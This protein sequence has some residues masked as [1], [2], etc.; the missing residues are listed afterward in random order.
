MD[1]TNFSRRA[2]DLIL[3]SE[4]L[5]HAGWPGGQSGVTLGRGYDLGY[6]TRSEFLT[7]WSPYLEPPVLTL[8]AGCVGI[9]GIPAR[10]RARM[11]R[12]RVVITQAVADRVFFSATL[13]KYIDLTKRTFPGVEKLPLDAQGALVSLVFNRGSRMVDSDP[14]IQ[15][16]RE[17]RAIR[18]A[19]VHGDLIDIAMQIRSMTRLWVGKGLDGLIK[20]REEEAELVEAAALEQIAANQPLEK[21]AS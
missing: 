10:D 21:K 2:L 13:P 7:D 9:I 20:R 14:V 6:H 19:I 16:R 5:D 18:D 17:M 12:G 11:L 8:L 15:E 4:G 1:A 3:R